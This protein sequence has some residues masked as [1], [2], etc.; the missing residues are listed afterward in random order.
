MA[1]K[2]GKGS[3]VGRK[4]ALDA[5]RRLLG[6][7]YSE[8]RIALILGGGGI[9]KTLL[10][11]EMLGKARKKK[12]VLAPNAPID[13]FSTDYRHIDG[14]QWK[15]IEIVENL[16]G[17]KGK[18]SPFARY[19]KGRTDTS[20]NFYD[21]LK[22]FCA[23]HPLVLAFDT[24]ENLD[25][26]ASNWLFKSERGG[27]QVPGLICIIAGREE[28]R[29]KK[30]L[31]EY[32][33]NPLVKEIP[34]SGF[35]LEE[36]EDFYQRIKNEFP[37]PLGDDDFLK[38]LGME[39]SDPIHKGI[40]RI[41][42]ITKGHPLKLEMAFRWPGTL[43]SENSLADLAELTTK[44]YEEKLMQYVHEWGT[45]GGFAVGSLPVVQPVFDTLTCM[46]YVV[47]RFDVKFLQFLVGEKF[48]RFGA[49][50]VSN[51][52][53]LD[54]LMRY[55]FV[56]PRGKG[57]GGLEIIQL[58]DEMAR[59][60]REHVW[61]S[62]DLSGDKRREIYRAVIRCY[63]TLIEQASK[64]L[65]ETLQ[66]EQLYN[67]LQLDPDGV[68]IQRWFELAELGNANINKLLPGE[69]KEHI[70]DYDVETQV[71]IHSRIAEMEKNAYHINQALGHWEDVKELGEKVKRDDW[72]V[73]ALRGQFNCIWMQ[74]PDQALE[75]YLKP[76]LAICENV[77]EKLA[78]IYYEM[79]FAYNQM[80]DLK[81]AVEWYEKGLQHLQKHPDN[82]PLEATLYNDAGYAYLQQG[83]WGDASKYLNEALDIRLQR[84]YKDTERSQSAMFVGWSYNTLGEHH[85]YDQIQ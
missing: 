25:R 5:F 36:A 52:E 24:F 63:D 32:R 62:L 30:E 4:A 82:S 2:R 71:K 41:W 40:E 38:A 10:V 67:M 35:T 26:V 42:E 55:F 3:F 44:Q 80:Q 85:R 37:S 53:V 39:I 84:F 81:Q 7:P 76:A 68:G 78:L 48:I 17:L 65:A 61:P 16:S 49:S 33:G 57:D 73:D 27:L 18:Q 1:T 6:K 51:E 47:R 13:L 70:K 23:E 75:K 31:D 11:K 20:D 34:I 50:T 12:G 28:G 58:H 79:G 66:V 45:Q 8:K 56:K 74:D 15:I 54:Y 69:I 83:K 9:G 59:L 77:P 46:A 64:E 72:V 14:I 19:E 60:V 21:C 22:E 29:D 43:L